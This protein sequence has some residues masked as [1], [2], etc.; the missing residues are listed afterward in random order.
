MEIFPILETDKFILRKISMDD[1][2]N[3]FEVFSN[4]NIMKFYGMFPVNDISKINDLINHFDNLFAEDK[5]IRWAI[6]SKESN[7]LIGTCG[8]H[9]WNQ[10]HFRAEIGYELK[11]L[12]W[13]K[14]YMNEVLKEIINY[15]F[16]QMSSYRIEALIYPENEK[17][18][19]SLMK[20]GF[21]YEGFLKGYAF[22]RNIH[23]DLKLFSIVNKI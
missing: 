12:H 21:E 20:I 6:I 8:F 11:E 10:K 9:N 2:Y 13:G 19:N 23:Q 5:G 3:L 15:G 16:S 18:Y 14:G 4:E 22:Y 1:S 7:D 17:S